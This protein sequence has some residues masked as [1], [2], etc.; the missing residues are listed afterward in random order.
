MRSF[1]KRLADTVEIIAEDGCH[2]RELI[3]PERDAPPAGYSLA[4]AEIAPGQSTLN[5][6]LTAEDELYYFLSGRGK[7]T[8]ADEQFDVASGDTVWVPRGTAQFVENCGEQP[9][10]WLNIVSPPWRLEHDQRVECD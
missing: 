9:L 1:R 8:I 4:Q 3:H 6:R 10:R 5:H 2:L 7:M